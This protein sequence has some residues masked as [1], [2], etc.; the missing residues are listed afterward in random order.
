M[1]R[2]I[3]TNIYMQVNFGRKFNNQLNCINVFAVVVHITFFRILTI[4]R[5]T[6]LVINC[7]TFIEIC[8]RIFRVRRHRV[9]FFF[10]YV[11]KPF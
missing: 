2:A 1:T 7:T 5:G 10:I 4:F 8:V 3:V 9:C 11:V 6:V